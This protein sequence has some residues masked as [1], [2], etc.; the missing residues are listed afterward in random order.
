MR[1][2]STRGCKQR[3]PQ[4]IREP[5]A[6]R[7]RFTGTYH[8]PSTRWTS[9]TRER[10]W[11]V[12]TRQQRDTTETDRSPGV[13][14][15]GLGKTER[16]SRGRESGAGAHTAAN[17]TRH[18]GD[19]CARRGQ[20]CTRRVTEYGFALFLRL[21]TVCASLHIHVSVHTKLLAGKTLLVASG[22]RTRWGFLT[23]DRNFGAFRQGCIR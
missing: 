12:R 21:Y 18:S 10:R 16:R 1:P 20:S 2:V 4:G 7:F 11:L 22:E 15:R 13:T 23:T 14:E 5:L 9:E 3:A 19:P 6:P 17:K 8:E